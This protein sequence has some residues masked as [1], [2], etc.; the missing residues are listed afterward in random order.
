MDS[1]ESIL[2]EK[3]NA[4]YSVR[5]DVVV[6]EAVETMCAAHVGALT[7]MLGDKLVGMFSER[8]L[9]K[10]VVLAR[11]D[12][13]R[14]QVGEVMTRHVVC[15][16]HDA[17]PREVMDVMTRERV[18]H[19]PVLRGRRVHGIVS[20]GDMVRWTLREREHAVE[21]LTEYVAGKYPG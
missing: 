8:D 9:M 19:M 11:R 14:V 17:S 18:R 12:P 13:A 2:E 4:L 21:Q 6:L 7:V 10:R 5:P 1:I 15:T 3:G 16:R 20:M